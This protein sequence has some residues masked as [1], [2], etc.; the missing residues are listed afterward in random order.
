M[1][2]AI[3]FPA[4]LDLPEEVVAIARTIEEAGFE[5]WCVGGA[6]RDRLLG[7]PAQDVDFATA[8]PPEEVQRLFRRTVGVGLRHGTVGV[9][10][11]H[12]RLHEV[13]TFR[14]DV[15]TDG[16]HATVAFGASLDE[17]LARRDFTINAIA[18]H[19]LRHDWRDP[20]G[21]ARDLSAGLIRAVGDPIERFREDY[22]RVLR[23]LRF[24]ARLGFRVEAST[25]DALVEGA[26][27]LASLSAERVRDEW[28]KGLETAQQVLEFVRLWHASGAAAVVLPELHPAPA[29]ARADDRPRDPVLL[30][31]LLVDRVDQVLA[32]LRG[33]N[34]EVQRAARFASAPT[35]PDGATD[36]AVRRW[37]H[38]AGPAADDLLAAHLLATG[39][40][41]AWSLAVAGIRAR[42]EAVERSGLAVSGQDLA[43]AGIP[44]GPAMGRIL[45]TLLA[46]VLDDPS[47]NDRDRLL[48]RARAL[49]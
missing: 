28:F 24:A 46:D 42:G 25:W 14:R 49:A 15:T 39:Q 45:D 12:R 41:A 13:T 27:G 26:P 9:L 2:E 30:T 23:A 44:P 31:C 19:P 5:T 37:L 20:F 34:A 40:P 7:G 11:A 43:A 3:T 47:R 1:S 36:A 18:Y 21:G 22:L 38:A 16:R 6:L 48:T 8:A 17:D 32:R 10:D 29:L 33:S 4:R 35:A